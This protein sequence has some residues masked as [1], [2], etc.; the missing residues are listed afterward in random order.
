MKEFVL[1]ADL[2]SVIE[3]QDPRAGNGRPRVELQRML[4]MHFVQHW[5][6]WPT[7]RARTRC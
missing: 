1:W 6:T 2:C 5:F 3:P 4:R 7:L